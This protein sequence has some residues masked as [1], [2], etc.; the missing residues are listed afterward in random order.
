[1]DTV[2]LGGSLTV[3]KQSIG[4]A[5]TAKGFTGV[6]GILGI[7][8]ADLTAGTTGGNATVPTFT[9]NLMANGLIKEEVITVVFEPT[10]QDGARNGT[11]VVGST[12]NANIVG[13]IAWVPL[14]ETSPASNYWGVDLALQYGASGK[15][16]LP[17]TAGI[18]DTGTTLVMLATDAF[19][20][21]QNATGAV[22]DK[23]VDRFRKI[24]VTI[25]F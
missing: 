25:D 22:L 6:D 14:T 18:V 8:P 20:S 3:E 12:N 17:K 23:Y 10:T 13:D 7:G 24:D 4:V 2:S 19:Q 16:V 1:M 9:D 11:L 21:Y 5:E 15:P